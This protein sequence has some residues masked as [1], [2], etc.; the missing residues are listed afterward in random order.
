MT[1]VADTNVA[2]AANGR[3]THADARCQLTCV[4]RLKSL[5]AGEVVA[6]D[7]SGLILEESGGG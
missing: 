2:I 5:A 6:I 7:D 4:E 1:F 3:E